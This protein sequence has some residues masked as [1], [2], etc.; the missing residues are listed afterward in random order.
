MYDDNHFKV[1]TS[2][3]DRFDRDFEI[4]LMRVLLNLVFMGYNFIIN[5]FMTGRTKKPGYLNQ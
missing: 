5:I 4:D 2:I 3:D 1:M